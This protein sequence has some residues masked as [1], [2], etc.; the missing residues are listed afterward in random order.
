MTKNY[1]EM[2]EKIDSQNGLCMGGEESPLCRNWLQSNGKVFSM[3]LY[4]QFE[5]IKICFPEFVPINSFMFN[6]ES[7]E[8]VSFIGQSLCMACARQCG[9]IVYIHWK[10]MSVCNLNHHLGGGESVLWILCKTCD[11]I[12]F[13]DYNLERVTVLVY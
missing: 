6:W 9:T 5:F 3:R 7:T 10:D 1:W 2:N 8:M 4:A 12:W 13:T 11:S